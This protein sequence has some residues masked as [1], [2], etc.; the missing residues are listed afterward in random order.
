MT[1]DSSRGVVVLFGGHGDG[2]FLADTWERRGTTWTK[3]APAAS[4][5]GRTGASLVYDSARGVAVLFGG[6]N[7]GG[8]SGDASFLA[9]TWEWDGT[10][11][12]QRTPPV[13]PGARYYAAAAFDK[14]RNVTVLFGGSDRGRSVFS[15]TWEW[16]GNSW[17][18][19]AATPPTPSARADAPMACDGRRGVCTMF[20][21]DDG[22]QPTDTWERDG[23]TWG[24]RSPPSSPPDRRGSTMAFDEARSVSVLFGGHHGPRPPDGNLLKDTWEWDGSVWTERTTSTAPAPRS[25]HGMAY[26][27]ARAVTVLFGGNGGSAPLGDTWEWDGATWSSL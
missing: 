11:W 27:S 18:S 10:Q 5:P 24:Q 2:S 21:G 23:T 25:A 17:R 20:G 16:D 15:E 19:Y 22:T 1:Y 8:G 4:P 13:S 26:D 12:T 14:S 7:G 6:Q 3:V 9:D